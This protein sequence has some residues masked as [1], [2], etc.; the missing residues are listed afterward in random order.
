MAD[1][2]LDSTRLSTGISYRFRIIVFRY[3]YLAEFDAFSVPESSCMIKWLYLADQLRIVGHMY[4]IFITVVA[5]ITLSLPW[6]APRVARHFNIAVHSAPLWLPVVAAVCYLVSGF[7]PDI[8]ISRQTTTFQE[9][10]VGGGFF[11]ALLFI[12]FTR[13]LGWRR[14]W[15]IMLLALFAWTS[16]LGVANE[17]LEFTVTKLNLTQIDITDTSWDLTANTVG[18][19]FVFVVW[20]AFELLNSGKDPR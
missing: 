4:F 3:Y 14:H 13:L 10:L 1:R 12:Y 5:L 9:H 6:T 11:T 15:V 17:L 19:L 7:V 2:R 18:S 20:Q 8:H 16:A